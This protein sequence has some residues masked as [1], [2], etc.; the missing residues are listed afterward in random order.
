MI[1]LLECPFCGSEPELR[2]HKDNLTGNGYHEVYCHQCDI[3]MESSFILSDYV[4]KRSKGTEE[5]TLNRL[6]K[7]WNTRVKV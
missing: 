3:S 6:V 4:D 7:K 1:N 2:T 5:K